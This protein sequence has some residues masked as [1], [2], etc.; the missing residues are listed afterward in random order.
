VHDA[1]V[2]DDDQAIRQFDQFVQV[3]AD[4]QHGGAVFAC[5]D[6]AR[7]DVGHGLEVEAEGGVGCDQHEGAGG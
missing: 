5:R 7:V 4:Q 3:F 1:A 6:G 2:R